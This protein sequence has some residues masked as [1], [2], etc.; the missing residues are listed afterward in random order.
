MK[1]HFE[2][3]STQKQ[4]DNGTFAFIV[5]PQYNLYGEDKVLV[6]YQSGYVRG[7]VYNPETK[8]MGIRK[9][10]FEYAPGYVIKYDAKPYHVI[11]RINEDD[12][13][14][15]YRL[16]FARMREYVTKHNLI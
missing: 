4:I 15:R 13:I 6:I 9:S 16:M 7:S 3:I 8:K 5:K 2:L 14:E 10:S 12:V 11:A 1:K